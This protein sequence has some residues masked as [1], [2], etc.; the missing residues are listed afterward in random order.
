M[1]KGH[2]ICL[3]FVGVLRQPLNVIPNMDSKFCR[4]LF[5]MPYE[6][7]NGL[8][9]E[10]YVI[11]INN[12]PFPMVVISP[13]KIIVKADN[14][15]S[16]IKYVEA[17]KLE[18]KRTQVPISLTA[19]GINS[20]CQ[21]LGL[22]VNADTWLWNHFINKDIN[23]GN[24]Y[25]VCNKI[26]MRIGI[27]DC[28]YVNIELEPRQGNRNGLFANINHHHNI[29]LDEMPNMEMLNKYIKESEDIV[30]SNII[31]KIVEN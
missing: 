12:K 13:T 15:D 4:D 23:I 17:V 21:W 16:L 7:F 19:F 24:E 20:E 3:S 11:A 22:D 14:R 30:N 2:L 25:H 27:N 5:G 9:P 8:T 6:T 28:Q 1:E 29:M 10:G 31:A 26:N 18:L